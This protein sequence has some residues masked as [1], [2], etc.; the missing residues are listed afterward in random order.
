MGQNGEEMDEKSL[1]DIWCC[2]VQLHN[3]Q[4]SI[5]NLSQERKFKIGR[6]GKKEVTIEE[7]EKIWNKK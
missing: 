3:H 4:F 2:M 1:E 5:P 7:N 6:E